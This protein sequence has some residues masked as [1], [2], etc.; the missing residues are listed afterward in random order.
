MG[1][2]L[3]RVK[4]TEI[5]DA[6]ARKSC[7][8]ARMSCARVRKNFEPIS[9]PAFTGVQRKIEILNDNLLTIKADI[10]DLEVRLEKLESEPLAK[11]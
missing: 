8:R 7:A 2:E 11:N 3:H 9:R 1:R 10:R 4:L 6:Q 5:E